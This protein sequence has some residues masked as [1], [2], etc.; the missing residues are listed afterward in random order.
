MAG[1]AA[2][3]ALI[4]GIVW[5]LGR[6]SRA[7]KP[8]VRL[9]RGL[10][11]G[12]ISGILSAHSLLVAKVAVEL[13]VRTI[14]DGK[15]QFDRYQSW[16]ILIGLVS[17]ALTQLYFLHL[18]LKLVSTSV[19]YPLVFCVYN[20]IAILDGLIYFHQTSLLSPIDAGMICLGTVV[21]LSGVLSLSW[22]LSDEQ[23]HPVVPSSALAPGLGLVDDSETEYD[24]FEEVAEEVE[25]EHRRLE[26]DE[27]MTP[28]SKLDTVLG[29]TRGVRKVIRFGEEVNPWADERAGG[30]DGAIGY[31][32]KV[33]ESPD[34]VLPTR[35]QVSGPMAG[36]VGENT[37][38]LLRNP[39]IQRRRRRRSTGFHGFTAR[40]PKE[41]ER[42]SSGHLGRLG[43]MFN[44]HHDR[45]WKKDGDGNNGDD[46][47][48]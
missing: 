15:N 27:P 26:G 13:L 14:V 21:L 19:L 1:Q 3:V 6:E 23:S 7:T 31:G 30:Q 4:L 18:G 2:L 40:D 46:S 12:C 34:A 29:A 10:A 16:I 41:E 44:K 37:P 47:A 38:L 5:V 35:R 8:R 11:Y 24:E 28:T 43:R 17:L 36:T 42:K 25:E 22:Q 32:T 9:L 45:W 48:V 20:I 33:D 39:S